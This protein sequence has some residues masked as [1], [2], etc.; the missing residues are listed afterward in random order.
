MA[1]E[2]GVQGGG[3]PADDLARGLVLAAG[4]DE[5]RPHIGLVGDT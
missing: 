2:T 4:N 5:S 1:D 3:I